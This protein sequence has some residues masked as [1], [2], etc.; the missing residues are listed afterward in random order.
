MAKV[1]SKLTT[2]VVV[3]SC[4]LQPCDAIFDWLFGLLCSLPILD[5]LCGGKDSQ[6]ELRT[7]TTTSFN[8]F[9][10]LVVLGDD[11]DENQ[12]EWEVSFAKTSITL[13]YTVPS[14]STSAEMIAQLE[15]LR[16]VEEENVRKLLLPDFTG[17]CDNKEEFRLKVTLP[18]SARSICVG[19]DDV[20]ACRLSLCP[21]GS[22]LV[23]NVRDSSAVSFA[24]GNAA[25]LFGTS[26]FCELVKP[27]GWDDA[28]V[29]T[30]SGTSFEDLLFRSDKDADGASNIVEF[31]GAGFIS[32]L[33]AD[34]PQDATSDK[35][36]PF[37]PDTDGDLLLDS[38][39]LLYGLDPLTADVTTADTD[40]DSL[41]LFNE[42][43][44]K[45]N[46]FLADSDGDGVNDADEVTVGT[47]PLDDSSFISTSRRIL[48]ED[49]PCD[50]ADD[51]LELT[52]SVG[53]PSGSRSERW[54]M[55]V[56]SV[57]HQATSFG[58]VSTAT[59]QFLPGKYTITVRH[60][61]SNLSSPDYDYTASVT[62]ESN[63]EWQVTLSDQSSLLG[64][65]FGNTID[66]TV[67]KSATIT[68]QKLDECSQITSCSACVGESNCDWDI[69]RKACV[70][71]CSVF[72]QFLSPD[73]C[74][75][76]R[77]K[78]WYDSEDNL[79]W[80]ENTPQCPCTVNLV[81][82]T[83]T[84]L[85]IFTTTDQYLEVPNT[86]EGTE[87]SNDGGCNPETEFCTYHPGA[88]GCLRGKNEESGNSGNQCCYNSNLQHISGGL[89]A[90]TPDLYRGEFS[91]NAIPHY[92]QDVETFTHCCVECEIE[93]Y[94]SYYVGGEVDGS[95]VR[96]A[97]EDT[98]GCI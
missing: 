56:G 87:W 80:I 33:Y 54:T 72:P 52:L 82:E 65:H 57:E 16:F 49:D 75:C 7:F 30:G 4:L 43:I 76:E 48:Q 10:E 83:T 90:G 55:Q 2:T 73:E 38:Y 9:E 32:S 19:S 95:N 50:S 53:D 69:D 81:T 6:C 94:C 29:S 63:A 13:E 5:L 62:A 12:V 98:R 22:E 40:G 58:V 84:Y 60:R 47:D 46:P 86:P 24:P 25:A 78:A 34:L 45:T 23:L 96:G 85:G 70:P 36:N 27:A 91:T 3:L 35:T 15:N 77:C 18:R 93:D 67:G 51:T 28:W 17:G 92:F 42:Q 1:F 61:D 31:Y 41:D 59:Y 26:K 88:F 74:P 37:D 11:I 44:Y 66:R 14:Q 21:L 39:E 8:P 71:D 79:D 64:T 97:R 68:L 89:P 20:E